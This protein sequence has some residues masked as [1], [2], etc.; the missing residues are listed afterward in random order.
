MEEV[1]KAV[2]QMTD[3]FEKEQGRRP[4][5]MMAKM[6][7]DG[8]EQ[9]VRIF[10]TAYADMGFDVD[11]GPLFQT[12]AEA[13]QDAAD[14][15]VHIVDTRYLS[16]EHKTLLPQLVEKLAKCGRDDIMVVAGGAIPAED[17]QFLYQHGIAAIY[18]ADVS[19]A[20][21]AKDM[22]EKLNKIMADYE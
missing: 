2:R 12:P 7:Q 16:A 21:C 9:D 18:G 1:I 22:M 5:I 6:G 3:D 11:M 14:N 15:D 20:D 13:A 10:A 4:R 19:V 17:Y 8:N